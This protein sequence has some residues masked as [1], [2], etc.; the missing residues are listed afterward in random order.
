MAIASGK[1]TELVLDLC[2]GFVADL[3]D[4]GVDATLAALFVQLKFFGVL[5]Q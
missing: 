2:E 3:V 5:P 4:H 1:P